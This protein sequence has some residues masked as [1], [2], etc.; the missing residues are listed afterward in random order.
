MG[1]STEHDEAARTCYDA[2]LL[3]G[4]RRRQ[5]HAGIGRDKD[6]DRIHRRAVA[7]ATLVLLLTAASAITLLHV[8][9]A[10]GRK[11][12]LPSALDV[13]LAKM[14][15]DIAYAFHIT[16]FTQSHIAPCIS[17]TMD[18]IRA[19]TNATLRLAVARHLAGEVTT[20]DLKNSDYRI[21]EQNL[22]CAVDSINDTYNCLIIAEAHE[23]ERCKFLFDALEHFKEGAVATLDNA[24]AGQLNKNRYNGVMR[25]AQ[26][27]A[28]IELKTAPSY[29]DIG[30]FSRQYPKF[31]P[32]AQK[33]FRERFR[34]V[35]GIEYIPYSEKKAYLWGLDGTRWD[36][37]GIEWR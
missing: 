33:Y 32:E 21:R 31:S 12:D 8:F 30:I 1:G 20:L 14:T 2:R 25:E 36:G 34:E 15:N 22:R 11:A 24:P 26:T 19:M 27:V 5:H 4:A 35:F 7:A 16:D 6:M 37:K 29:L 10:S 13:E 9:R 28:R 3:G 18:K 17:G 23:I